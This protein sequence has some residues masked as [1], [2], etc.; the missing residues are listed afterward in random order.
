LNPILEELFRTG[1]MQL[2]ERF[3]PL[4][5]NMSQDEGR[6]IGEAFRAAAPV[7]SLEIGC[8]DGV[9]SLFA[10]DALADVGPASRHV[11]IDPFQSTQWEGLGIENL[12]RAGHVGRVDLIEERSEIALP[13]LHAAGLRI[14][15]AIID[16]WH[17]FDH[18]LID[19]FYVNKML[20]VGGVFVLDDTQMPALNR[21][22]SHICSYPCYRIHGMS[23]DSPDLPPHSVAFQKMA[24]DER[25][26]NWHAP[27]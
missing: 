22:V 14:Q 11:I 9:A 15:A 21:L 4:H 10:C 16:G 18:A 6:L 20:D 19:F 17:T 1:G 5:S 13:R 2:N 3:V 7:T 26:W 12:R 24:A 27:F 23:T 25:P 8:A